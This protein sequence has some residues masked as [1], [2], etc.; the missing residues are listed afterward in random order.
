[1]PRAATNRVTEV[2]HETKR[3]LIPELN[4]RLAVI[5]HQNPQFSYCGSTFYDDTRCI[6][7]QSMLCERTNVVITVRDPTDA[8]M[9]WQEL[10][11]RDTPETPYCPLVN[12]AN[13]S[14]AG[15]DWETVTN[16]PEELLAR[17]SNLSSALRS[18]LGTLEVA[19]HHYPIP[20]EGGLYSPCVCKSFETLSYRMW[21][22]ATQQS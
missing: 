6:V 9:S 14:K 1:M 20:E 11:R 15:G 2:I 12:M 5:Q 22:A 17:R 4:R 8:A 16:G 3:V 7:P 13:A 21:G 10:L 18:K 19:T